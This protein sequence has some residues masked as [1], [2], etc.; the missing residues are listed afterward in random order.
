MQ[1]WNDICVNDRVDH[2]WSWCSKIEVDWPWSSCG[3]SAVNWTN[4]C[5][6][7]HRS[8]FALLLRLICC[9]ILSLLFP[10]N[11]SSFKA[12]HFSK[13]LPG[14]SCKHVP[15]NADQ[16]SVSDVKRANRTQSSTDLQSFC[17]A[18]FATS[19]IAR[20]LLVLGTAR[21]KSIM[22]ITLITI[23]HIILTFSDKQV[24]DMRRTS[25]SEDT[26]RSSEEH[27]KHKASFLRRLVKETQIWHSGSVMGRSCCKLLWPMRRWSQVKIH[28][29]QFW[30]RTESVH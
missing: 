25:C 3:E 8:S 13:F 28:M 26:E 12:T 15:V 14:M 27:S 11:L 16:T 24:P 19:I 29:N 9:G 1:V 30:L 22:I 5:R 7:A 10:F 2:N 23:I 20:T 21:R 4:P 18:F 17:N 6:H